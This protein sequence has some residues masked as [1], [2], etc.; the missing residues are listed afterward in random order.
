MTLNL[1]IWQILATATLISFFLAFV[2]SICIRD[3]LLAYKRGLLWSFL[4]LFVPS[5]VPMWQSDVVKA[6][7][8]ATEFFM[9]M[10][11]VS[12]VWLIGSTCGVFISRLIKRSV[13]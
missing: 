11:P 9:L 3:E 7:N 6:N 4:V 10:I 5:C 12:F 8:A 2:I 13:R 1:T